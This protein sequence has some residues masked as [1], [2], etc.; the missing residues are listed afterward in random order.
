MEWI[1]ESKKIDKTE[2]AVFQSRFEPTTSQ[3]HVT[4]IIAVLNFFEIKPLHYNSL[5]VQIYI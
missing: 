2:K 3:L 1:R 5:K 4:S